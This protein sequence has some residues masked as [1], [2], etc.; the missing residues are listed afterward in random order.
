MQ[1]PTKVIRIVERSKRGRVKVVTWSVAF[2]A[3]VLSAMS[4]PGG[5]STL[6][7]SPLMTGSTNLTLQSQSVVAPGIVK[8]SWTFPGGSVV[9]VDTAGSSVSAG[10]TGQPG[11]QGSC[12]SSTGPTSPS[13][14]ARYYSQTQ[15]AQLTYTELRALGASSTVAQSM[16][17]STLPPGTAFSPSTTPPS[18]T[19]TSSQGSTVSK[20]TLISSSIP[21]G[22]Y[23]H[24][25]CTQTTGD[26]GNASIYACLTQRLLQ[27]NSSGTY[28]GD[29]ITSSASDNDWADSLTS[30]YGHETYTYT[31][32]Y[33]THSLVQWDPS[34]TV[35]IGNPVQ[36]TYGV[37]LDGF[38]V[39][40]T[41]TLYPGSLQ[42]NF[43]DS[44]GSAYT[45]F[46]STWTGCSGASTVSTP[47]SDMVKVSSGGDLYSHLTDGIGWYFC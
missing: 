13:G 19:M 29:A 17:K 8:T 10:C 24:S 16:A 22:S 28:V 43:L 20:A 45:G 31:G 4:L 5:A 11:F 46:G 30:A 14:V 21:V 27:D 36:V 38:G 42:P 33:G 2:T 18:G 41:D 9:A 26:A 25:A 6:S 7:A 34:A 39:S 23:F 3:T 32:S 35:P 1:I 40:A 12:W 44:N 47:S 37:S 15:A